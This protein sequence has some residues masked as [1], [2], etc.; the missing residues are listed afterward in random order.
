ML[1][2]VLWKE[3][4]EE[5]SEAKREVKKEDEVIAVVDLTEETTI[6]AQKERKMF[7]KNLM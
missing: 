1:K 2:M 3:R 7:M 5:E 4:V 6:S